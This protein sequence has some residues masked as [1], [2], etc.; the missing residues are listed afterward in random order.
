M[1]YEK[2]VRNKQSQIERMILSMSLTA[3]AGS[4]AL[5]V[6]LTMTP[7]ILPPDGPVLWLPAE[8]DDLEWVAGCR[9]IAAVKGGLAVGDGR[10]A[11]ATRSAAQPADVW[12]YTPQTVG[13]APRLTA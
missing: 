13:G 4:V 9:S 3:Q 2:L 12:L 8:R 10:G 6:V 7:E 11:D 1:A 5:A